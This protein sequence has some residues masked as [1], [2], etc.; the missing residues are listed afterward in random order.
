MCVCVCVCVC[1]RNTHVY[2]CAVYV[3]DFLLCVQST[4][5]GDLGA[6][7][8]VYNSLTSA[9]LPPKNGGWPVKIYLCG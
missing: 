8:I 1:T 6:E 7:T 2:M 9:K 5:V 4:Y 3:R